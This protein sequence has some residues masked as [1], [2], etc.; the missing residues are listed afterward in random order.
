[1]VNITKDNALKNYRFSTKIVRI[2][3]TLSMTMFAYIT[4]QIIESAKG[5]VLSMGSWFLPIVIGVSLILPIGII[6]YFRKINRR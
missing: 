1:M 5:K 6:I 3:N 4:Y 2:V